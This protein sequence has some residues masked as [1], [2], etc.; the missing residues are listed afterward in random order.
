MASSYAP[1]LDQI[2]KT[3]TYSRVQEVIESGLSIQLKKEEAEAVVSA[4]GGKSPFGI[5]SLQGKMPSALALV[6]QNHTK[7]G[8]TSLNHTED[9]VLV[10][11]FGPGSQQMRGLTQNYEFF[12][13][14]LAAKG[15]KWENPTMSF[16]DAAKAMEK[17]KP[18]PPELYELYGS[19]EE[20]FGH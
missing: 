20:D 1:M 19:N 12:N 7:V 5:L 8:W 18:E 16:E 2:G 14:M 9:H 15:L 6:L 17:A 3:P 11:A 4:I 13:L 10:S